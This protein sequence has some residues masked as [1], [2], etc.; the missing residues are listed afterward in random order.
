M[1]SATPK[2][3][4]RGLST[5]ELI[6]QY[7]LAISSYAGR[8]TNTSPRQKRINLIVDVLSERADDGDTQAEKWLLG[9]EDWP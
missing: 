2:A 7:E 3:K 9:A 5:A 6:G 8:Y 1:T 4:L